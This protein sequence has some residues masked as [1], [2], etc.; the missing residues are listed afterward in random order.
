MEGQ[1]QEAMRWLEAKLRKIEEWRPKMK[2]AK[3]TGDPMEHGRGRTKMIDWEK[4]SGGERKGRTVD[5]RALLRSKDKHTRGM[6]RKE[7]SEKWGWDRKQILQVKIHQRRKAMSKY[8]RTIYFCAALTLCILEAAIFNLIIFVVSSSPGCLA[9]P[10]WRV[11]ALPRRARRLP[12][13]WQGGADGVPGPGWGCSPTPNTPAPAERWEGA[14]PVDTAVTK[15]LK[16]LI[17]K[18]GTWRCSWERREPDKLSLRSGN[19]P[20]HLCNT[21]TPRDD[22]WNINMVNYSGS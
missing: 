2:E 3:G 10:G 14:S 16:I 22:N 20:I 11:L 7:F 9:M 5:T 21:Q 18:K 13:N 8:S 19:S 6:K 4:G 12:S 17:G 1:S 15:T